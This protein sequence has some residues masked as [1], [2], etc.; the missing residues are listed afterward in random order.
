MY[1]RGA[2]AKV[3]VLIEEIRQVKGDYCVVRVGDYEQKS[4]LLAKHGE[5]ATQ[6]HQ[7]FDLYVIL[8]LC[9]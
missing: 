9:F 3:T 1:L 5:E 2:V 7:T 6:L 4:T 8:Y